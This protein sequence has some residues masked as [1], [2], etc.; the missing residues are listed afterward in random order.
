MQDPRQALLYCLDLS[1]R[2]NSARQ[3]HYVLRLA[4]A[5]LIRSN[6]AVTTSTANTIT[7]TYHSV[8]LLAE[9]AVTN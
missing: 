9:A 8:C 1:A 5:A 6:T 3:Q 2:D 4:L 7:Y